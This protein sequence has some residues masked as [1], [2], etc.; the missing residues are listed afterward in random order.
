MADE[1]FQRA[2]NTLAARGLFQARAEQ[3]RT[4]HPKR[5]KTQ[6]RKLFQWNTGAW[7]RLATEPVFQVFRST[8]LASVEQDEQEMLTAVSSALTPPDLP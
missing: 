1:V 6:W 3:G 5:E 8:S 7:N 2:W 4:P